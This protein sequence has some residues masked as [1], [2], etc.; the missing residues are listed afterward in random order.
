MKCDK[1]KCNECGKMVPVHYGY[2]AYCFHPVSR[3][4]PKHTM[5]FKVLTAITVIWVLALAVIAG[6]VVYSIY[7]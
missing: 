2:C 5:L 4:K 6:A 3:N 1:V 7:K